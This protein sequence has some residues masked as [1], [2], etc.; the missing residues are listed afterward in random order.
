[1]P[2]MNATRPDRAQETGGDPHVTRVRLP[3]RLLAAGMLSLPIEIRR[4]GVIWQKLYAGIGG[5][6]FAPDEAVDRRSPHGIQ[7]PI[8][9][10]HGL[11]LRL[12]LQNWADR[13]SYFNGRYYQPDISR[14]I[15]TL[16]QPGD[17]Y[18]DVGANIGMTALLARSRIG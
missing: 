14:L 12:D 18:V 7:E 16:L 4:F 6:G 5:G 15:E 13:R 17:Q 9:G 10:Q 2:S 11:R 3:L 1:M 8:R